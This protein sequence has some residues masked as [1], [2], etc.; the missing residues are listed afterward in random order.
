MNLEPGFIQYCCIPLITIE[1]EETY[2]EVSRA[3]TE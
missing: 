2:F 1:H 3:A